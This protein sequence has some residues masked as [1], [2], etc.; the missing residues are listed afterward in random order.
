[1]LLQALAVNSP[2]LGCKNWRQ[3]GGGGIFGYFAKVPG[4]LHHAPR[5][6]I[7]LRE[8]NRVKEKASDRNYLFVCPA[9]SG[10]I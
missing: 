2:L 7:E 8:M 4:I 9:A 10:I 5:H 3:A 6:L 1:M